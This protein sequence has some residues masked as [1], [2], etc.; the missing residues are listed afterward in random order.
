[1]HC[2]QFTEKKGGMLLRDLNRY[3]D[4]CKKEL[5]SIGIQYRTPD[6]W[7]SSGRLKTTLGYTS[8]RYNNINDK[9]K[10]IISS[11]PKI[12]ISKRV[13]NDEYPERFLKET[14]IHELIHTLDGCNNHGKRFQHFA[15]KVRNELGYNVGTYASQEERELYYR[16]FEKK[17]REYSIECPECGY[18][19]SYK[20]KCKTYKNAEHYFCPDCRVNL[21]RVV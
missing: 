2:V 3:V 12:V 21:K 1:M 14:I 9:R 11:V 4:I 13:L 10:G 18:R 7:E 6:K 19:W 20:I 8:L 17:K 5:D 16:M 15:G